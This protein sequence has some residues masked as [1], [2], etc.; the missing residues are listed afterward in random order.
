MYKNLKVMNQ[1]K[2]GRPSKKVLMEVVI[3]QIIDF[4][5]IEK[6]NKLD[7]DPRM[8]ESME[9][10]SVLDT[11]I[12]HEGGVPC[13]T[14]IMAVG[15]PGVGKT[16]VTLDLVSKILNKNKT[17]KVLFISAE[18]GRKQMFKYTQ[19]F[20][21]FGIVPTLFI[22]DYV[23]HNSKDVIEQCFDQGYDLILIDSLAEVIDSVRS[24]NGWD[25]RTAE[26]WIVELMK[27]QNEGE[28]NRNL[29]TTFIFIQQVTKSGDFVGSNKLKHL[30]DAMMEMRRESEKNGGGTY[31]EFSKNRNGNVGIK[32]GYQLQNDSIYYGT[33][34]NTEDD[35]EISES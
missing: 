27:K 18:M 24:D 19:R 6:L 22:S 9:S 29:Y 11:L 30:T 7:I 14:N 33:L 25:R 28:N 21:N 16:T 5:K 32:F 20:T 10:D 3:P 13:G 35:F 34:V 2:R 23:D 4:N 17:R 1:V 31:I 8:L 26:S 12:S 15:D